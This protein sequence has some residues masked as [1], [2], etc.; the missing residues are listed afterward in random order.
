M[1]AH[2]SG[3][4]LQ[5]S[6][7]CLVIDAGGIGYEVIVPLSTFYALPGEGER[8]NL[9]IHTHVREDALSLFG[10]HSRLEKDLFLMLIAV[11]GIGPKLAVNILSGIGPAELQ[12]AM[13]R[14]DALRLQSIPGV[15]KKTAERI[16]LE[17]KDRA[18]KSLGEREITPV[19]TAAGQDKELVDDALSALTNL[20]YHAKSAR[21]A[22]EMVREAQSDITLEVLIREA[23]KKLA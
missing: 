10:F 9:H 14:G 7:Q 12:E 23:L 20:G 8:V 2:L 13:A 1:I 16:A 17:L 21:K 3:I 4:M 6:T 11:S 15:G 19:S 22:V 18:L 5:K